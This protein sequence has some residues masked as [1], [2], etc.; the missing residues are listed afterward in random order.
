MDAQNVQVLPGREENTAIFHTLWQDKELVQEVKTT[1]TGAS[2]R[3]ILRDFKLRLNPD[4]A[5][6]FSVA[7]MHSAL[8]TARSLNYPKFPQTLIYLGVLLGLPNMRAVCKTTDGTDYIFQ[9]VVGTQQDAGIATVTAKSTLIWDIQEASK[10]DK[11]SP[12][13]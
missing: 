12:N 3:K 2:V 1:I 6:R 10:K 7:R 5:C 11:V 9:G 13:I 4:L 8:C